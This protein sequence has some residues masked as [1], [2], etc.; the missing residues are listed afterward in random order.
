VDAG[1]DF[2]TGVAASPGTISGTARV[3]LSEADFGRLQRGDILVCRATTPAWTPLFLVASGVVA[4][5]GGALSHAA[6]VARE[7]GTPAVLGTKVATRTMLDG[8]RYVVDGSEGRVYLE[9]AAGARSTAREM[10][11]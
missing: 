10:A 1:R 5:T 3:V 7:F 2:L 9:P 8:A 11:P 4:D 6:I